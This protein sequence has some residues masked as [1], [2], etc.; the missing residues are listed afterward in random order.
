MAS[1]IF[2]ARIGRGSLMNSRLSPSMAFTSACRA[3]DQNGSKPS[4]AMRRT[5][6]LTRSHAN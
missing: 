5:G 6:A 1:V 4:G 2:G 3:M